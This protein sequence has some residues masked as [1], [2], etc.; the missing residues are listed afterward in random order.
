MERLKNKI[1]LITGA[2]RG[3]GAETA[4]L[5]I[6][7]GARVILT[8]ILD[9]E[10]KAFAKS[11]GNQAE[12]LHLDVS[13]ESK[14]QAVVDQLMWVMLPVKLRCAIIPN[15]LHCIARANNTIFVVIH[16]TPAP[17]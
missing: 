11:L 15:R 5:F 7:E 17:F 4:R 6:Q 1:A 13:D 16:F 14:W 8:D 9:D 3:I 10:G 2:A 12:Y